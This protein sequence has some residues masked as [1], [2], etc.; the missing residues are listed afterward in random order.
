MSN[1]DFED[2]KITLTTTHK[3]KGKE[4]QFV[5]V[6]NFFKGRWGDSRNSQKMKLPSLFKFK[7]LDK[8][9][10]NEDE[11]RLFYVALTR[12]KKMAKIIFP[13]AEDF[14]LEDKKKIIS[15]FS[16]ELSDSIQKKDQV[17]FSEE[18]L[19]D[20][21]Q[22]SLKPTKKQVNF[23]TKKYFKYLLK[24]WKLSPT[25]LNNYLVSNK[26]FLES[27]LLN[28]PKL[29]SRSLVLGTAVHAGLEKMYQPILVGKE[30][31]NFNQIWTG[32]MKS[33]NQELVSLEDFKE[34]K[35]RGKEILV[36][37]Y[38]NFKDH[39]INSLGLE[40]SFGSSYQL[41]F[42][43]WALKGKIDRFDYLNKSS[44]EIIVIDYKTG[45]PKSENEVLFGKKDNWSDRERE[46]PM[47]IRGA[48]KRQVLFYKLLSDLDKSFRYK[49]VA[50][51]L[52]FVEKNS[53][54]KY[55]FI[56]IEFSDDDM[57]DFKNLLKEVIAEIKDLKFLEDLED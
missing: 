13:E 52:D 50:G 45:T 4:W 7:D 25:S 31:S 18:Q 49:T 20:F 38:E 56:D 35:I 44:K 33:L 5:F 23:E 32:F 26:R 37:Y 47:S 19:I 1:P 14:D 10:K 34:V 2:D 46:L 28:F 39:E 11:R 55:N 36:S 8:L 53:S 16:C 54:G 42:N 12:A 24:N 48:Y 40:Y 9:D 3:A 43:D 15:I 51:R 29:K 30:F 21:Y 22:E 27:S 41:I 6:I 17:R 57:L